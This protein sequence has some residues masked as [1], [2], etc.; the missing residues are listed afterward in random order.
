MTRAFFY[1]A[2][3][4]S[5]THFI[6]RPRFAAPGAITLRWCE[7]DFGTSRVPSLGWGEDRSHVWTDP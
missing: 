1:S 2:H 3:F 4:L 7:H 5:A 6:V